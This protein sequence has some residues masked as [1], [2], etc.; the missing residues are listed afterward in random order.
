VFFSPPHNVVNVNLFSWKVIMIVAITREI[1]SSSAYT[2]YG[3]HISSVLGIAE[4][5]QLMCRFLVHYTEQLSM[6]AISL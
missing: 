3:L 2:E 4:H 1:Y 5:L 6:K